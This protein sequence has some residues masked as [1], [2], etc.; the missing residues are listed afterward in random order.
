MR[1]A[2]ARRPG[3]RP[4]PQV[5]QPLDRLPHL[6]LCH[7]RRA[8]G[9]TAAGGT[10]RPRNAASRS[11]AGAPSWTGCG[12]AKRPV[13]GWGG[14]D[15][16]ED[17]DCSARSS[18]SRGG[19]RWPGR[20]PIRGT[21][22]LARACEIFNGGGR[23]RAGVRRRPSGGP[24]VFRR[25]GAHRVPSPGLLPACGV[26]PGLRAGPDSGKCSWPGGGRGALPAVRVGRGQRVRTHRPPERTP[27]KSGELKNSGGMFGSTRSSGKRSRRTSNT[28]R[29]STRTICPPT[30]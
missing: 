28:M 20:G 12:S 26:R 7:F 6:S 4:T 17:Q 2:G 5:G 21:D 18:G 23:H 19:S 16:G 14:L 22:G 30:Q 1:H 27:V 13:R 25:S 8:A 10:G 9:P 29:V 3:T 15:P 11:M 24:M